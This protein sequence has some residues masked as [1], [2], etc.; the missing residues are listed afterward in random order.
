MSQNSRVDISCTYF[1]QPT[2]VELSSCNSQVILNSPTG[3]H[4]KLASDPLRRFH[5][6]ERFSPRV[7]A[8]S[9]HVNR[10][11]RGAERQECEAAKLRHDAGELPLMSLSHDLGLLVHFLGDAKEA[12]NMIL[13]ERIRTSAIITDKEDAAA[14]ADVTGSTSNRAKRARLSSQGSNQK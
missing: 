11:S 3:E 6:T 4:V 7:F 10:H 8:S 1:L 13:S 14:I 5:F 9:N 12:S 2:R